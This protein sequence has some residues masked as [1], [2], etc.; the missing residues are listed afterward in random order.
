MAKAGNFC[1]H[2]LK[3]VLFCIGFS[4][5]IYKGFDSVQKYRYANLSTKVTMMN[6][7]ETLLPVIAVCPNYFEAYNIRLVKNWL[8]YAMLYLFLE[9]ITYLYS[10]KKT[11]SVP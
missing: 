5:T 6:S 1:D 8:C 4:L 11:F 10:H 3:S 9:H 7:F 2:H